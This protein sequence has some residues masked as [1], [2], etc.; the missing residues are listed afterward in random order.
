MRPA[1]TSLSSGAGGSIALPEK[2]ASGRKVVGIGKAAFKGIKSGATF[3]CP[4]SKVKAYKK[5]LAKA[6]AP[7]N[8][9]V[10]KG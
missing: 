3:K 2:D 4:K 6:G 5:L 1:E 10:K 8:A 9:T 7:K